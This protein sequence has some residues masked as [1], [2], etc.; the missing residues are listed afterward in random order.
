M[1]TMD[2]EM[3]RIV[4]SR[5]VTWHQTR[6]PLIS[7]APTECY[8]DW[9]GRGYDDFVPGNGTKTT[10]SGDRT[11]SPTWSTSFPRIQLISPGGWTNKSP[12][13]VTFVPSPPNTGTN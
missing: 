4:H 12:G 9:G 3:G 8:K 13:G 10:S 5:D 11:T 2:A 7:P 1:K 6:E